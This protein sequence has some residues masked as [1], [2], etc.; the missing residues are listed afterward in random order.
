[1]GE[2]PLGPLGDPKAEAGN[3][4]FRVRSTEGV[5]AMRGEQGRLKRAS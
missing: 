1:M 5:S 2:V 4:A 3:A